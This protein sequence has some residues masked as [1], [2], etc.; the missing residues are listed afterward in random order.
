MNGDDYYRHENMCLQRNQL[1]IRRVSPR[2][3]KIESSEINSAVNGIMYTFN[4]KLAKSWGLSPS[5]LKIGEAEAP[6]SYPYTLS[7]EIQMWWIH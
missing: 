4:F 5:S 1:H 2:K 6:C 7:V 3:F